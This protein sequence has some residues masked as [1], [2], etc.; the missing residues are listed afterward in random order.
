MSIHMY[1]R[2][3]TKHFQNTG[4]LNPILKGGFCYTQTISPH[5]KGLSCMG[6]KFN[7][8]PQKKI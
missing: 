1:I 6:L 3:H 8:N 4:T 7:I 5:T 2:I